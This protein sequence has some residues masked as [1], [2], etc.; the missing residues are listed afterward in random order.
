MFPREG[1]LLWD[2]QANLA[3]AFLKLKPLKYHFLHSEFRTYSL[4][5]LGQKII[6]GHVVGGGGGGG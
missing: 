1:A 2:P 3:K 6:L 4:E 5:N